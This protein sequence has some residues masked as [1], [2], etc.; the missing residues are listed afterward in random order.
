MGKRKPMFLFV[1]I[2]VHVSFSSHKNLYDE[3][4]YFHFK[5]ED[6]ESKTPQ[7]GNVSYVNSTPNH[8]K[9]LYDWNNI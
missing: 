1:E 6:E 5:Y 8:L 2:A 3:N 9:R 7:Q 4:Y